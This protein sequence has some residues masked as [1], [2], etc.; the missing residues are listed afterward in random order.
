MRRT[1]FSETQYR[2]FFRAKSS[3]K[4]KRKYLEETM[5]LWRQL[6]GTRKKTKPILDF[7]RNYW[8][9]A[10]FWPSDHFTSNIEQVKIFRFIYCRKSYW[11]EKI[12]L[13]VSDEP[14][15]VHTLPVF[16]NK[17]SLRAQDHE[18][19]R[20]RCCSGKFIDDKILQTCCAGL[21][22]IKHVMPSFCHPHYGCGRFWFDVNRERCCYGS[23]GVD[24][25]DVQPT[26]DLTPF[27]QI[28]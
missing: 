12:S 17:A 23:Q 6:Q 20:T 28:V 25:Q 1:T 15:V 22:V 21:I 9:C 26:C 5:R 27:N 10:M 19:L 16:Q 11:S 4:S 2:A 13:Q 18:Y 14:E 24:C 3:K 8:D 7:F